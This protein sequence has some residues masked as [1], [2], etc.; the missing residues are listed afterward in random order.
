[1]IMDYELLL[2]NVYRD[3]NGYSSSFNDSIGQYLLAGYL[4]KHDFVAKVF[5]GSVAECREILKREIGEHK[6]PIVGF[7]AAADNIRIVTHAVRWLK[8]RY[9]VT[10]VIGGPQAISLDLEFYRSTKNDYVIVG[11]GEIPLLKLMSYVVDGIGNLREIPQ[12]KYF[13]REQNAYVW[14]QCDTAIIT[15]LDSIPFPHVEDSLTGRLRN[16][17]MVGIITGRGC[18]N[19]C[20]FCYEGANAKHVRLRSIENVMEEIDYITAHNRSVEY[21][22]VYDDT[23]TLNVNRVIEFC[24]GMKKKGLKW[25][26]EGH[27]NFVNKHPELIREMVD[28]GLTCIQFGI[29][30]G[31]KKVLDAY[32]KGTDRESIIKAIDICKAAGLHG[33]TG[34]FIIGGAKETKETLRESRELAK[35]MLEH[36]RGIME[37]YT[38]FFAP[39]PNTQMVREPEQ[40]DMKIHG[41]L[42]DYSINTMRAPVVETKGLSTLDIYHEKEAFDLFLSEQYRENAISST[43][44]DV[45][46]GLFQNGRRIR[47]N[48]TWEASY[49][50]LNYIDV[51]LWHLSE[52]E[53]R[54]NKDGYIVRTFES[55][56]LEGQRMVTDIGVFE[57]L[58]KDVLLNASGVLSG[59]ETAEKLGITLEQLKEIYEKLNDRCLVYTSLW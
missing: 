23:F 27:V 39:Y 4:R 37:I 1:M 51:F 40:F 16:G 7:Y 35:E 8:E 56:V 44:A 45:L 43:K 13:D 46:Q 49:A 55:F 59:T 36:A 22:N 57:G 14:N 15:D 9:D 48:P 11:E 17:T 29:E 58:E 24:A 52:K 20:T 38:V 28:S 26:C 53:Q 5:S 2:L 18:P 6:V 47:I 25:F 54:F 3:T 30:S 12:L 42:V 19:H 41:E 50:A 32:R 31:S 10:T 33:I 34:N 21:I